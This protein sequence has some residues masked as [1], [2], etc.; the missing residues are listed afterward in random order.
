MSENLRRN[1][2]DVTCIG[3]YAYQL[4]CW[5]PKLCIDPYPS[6]PIANSLEDYDL[7]IM[8]PPQSIRDTMSDDVIRQMRE[9]WLLVCQN[10]PDTWRFDHTERLKNKLPFE[11]FQQ[12]KSLANASGAI[13]YKKFKSESVVA[14]TLA[15]MQEKMHLSDVSKFVELVAHDTLLYRHYK[16]RVVVSPDSAAPKKKIGILK[17]LFVYVGPLKQKVI[18]Q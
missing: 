9:K 1:G 4:K 11:V 12:V 6:V 10:A 14:M 8:S 5:L 18:C 16:N 15:F 7:V 17:R 2:F 3:D 13:R